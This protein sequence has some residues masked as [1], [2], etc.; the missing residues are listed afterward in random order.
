MQKNSED[1]SLEQAK[2]FAQSDAGKAL[3]RALRA[4]K[5]NA[6]DTAME[7][8]AAG[9]YEALKKTVQQLASSP[10]VQALLKQFG[11]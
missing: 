9:D 10:Q 6:M 4:Q 5:G 3:F 2:K 7:Q 11:G 8:A 1:F